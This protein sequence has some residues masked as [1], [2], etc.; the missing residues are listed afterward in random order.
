V[1][2]HEPPPQPATPVPLRTI[3]F[4][5]KMA[6]LGL[7]R[8]RADSGSRSVPGNSEMLLQLAPASQVFY[9]MQD[10]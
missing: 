6:Y 5:E 7:G 2:G 3:S 10:K 4:K 8:P 9:I 1:S